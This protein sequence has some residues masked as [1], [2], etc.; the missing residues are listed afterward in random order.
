M[1]ARHGLNPVTTPKRALYRGFQAIGGSRARD[2]RPA[3]SS[4]HDALTSGRV[5]AVTGASS[6]I[7]EATAL[8]CAQAGAAV[9]LAARRIERIEALA[10]R[11]ETGEGGRALAIQ[12]TWARRSRPGR[13][14]QR[15]AAELGRLD[16][17]VNN[18]GV[19]LL[20][21]IAGAP[22]PRNGGG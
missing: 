2:E 4:A 3:V 11:I 22:T 15:T 1:P 21:P 14:S 10:E 12:P 19:M 18:A 6:G 16:V 7:G 9:S 17:L 20:G 5:V 13:S 8:A